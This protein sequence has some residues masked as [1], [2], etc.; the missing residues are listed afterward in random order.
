[1]Y[2]KT[3][4]LF[5]AGLFMLSSLAGCNPKVESVDTASATSVSVSQSTD[6]SAS[7]SV[8][9]SKTEEVKTAAQESELAKDA[10][11]NMVVG[12][13][14]GN[15][16]DSTG[17]WLKGKDVASFETG[18]GNPAASPYL[19]EHLSELGFKAV[20]MPVTWHY[21]FDEQGNIDEA[22]MQRVEEVVNMILD[23][24]MYCIINVH[25]D[26]GSDGWLRAST[27]NYQENEEI[28]RALWTNIATRFEGYSDRLL[29]EG[30]NEMLDENSEWNKPGNDSLK[31]INMYNQLFV[32]AVRATGGNN[33]TRN[34]IVN[35]YAGANNNY[36]LSGF[37]MPTDSVEGHL[38]AEVHSYCP[39]AFTSTEAT[40]TTMTDVFSDNLKPEVDEVVRQL[41]SHF[42]SKGIP[43]II[44]EF[45][46]ENKGNLEEREKWAAYVIS[47]AKEKGITCFYWDNGASYQIVSRY[48]TVSDAESIA[49]VLV[50]NA[51]K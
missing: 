42:L 2:K 36:V 11:S 31:A 30:F 24:D 17:E 5:L 20:R 15:T 19:F 50:E 3:I 38:I 39:W 7:N 40:W 47:T 35:S 4:G 26:T 13:N 37:E 44:G 48:M 45:G 1:M 9:E 41:D 51:N 28:V 16:F 33:A 49:N 23:N 14:L 25:H 18:W 10:V 21:H 32:D 29:F 34:L 8:K 6:T 43:C 27:A 22:W 12:W 46:S